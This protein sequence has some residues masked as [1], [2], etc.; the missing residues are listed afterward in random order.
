MRFFL[1]TSDSQSVRAG[2]ETGALPTPQN[3]TFAQPVVTPIKWYATARWTNFAAATSSTSNLAAVKVEKDEINAALKSMNKYKNSSIF[4]DGTGLLG[5]VSGSPSTTTIT[6]TGGNIYWFKRNM[7]VEFYSSGS[8]VAGPVKLTDVD[9]INNTVSTETN[10]SSSLTSGD[11]IYKAGTHSP[12]SVTNAE[13]LGIGAALSAT[14]SYLGVARTDERGWQAQVIDGGSADVD[15]DIMFQGEERVTTLA[16]E[17][18]NVED[19]DVV[20]HPTQFRKF[21]KLVSSRRRFMGQSADAGLSYQDGVEWEGKKFLFDPDCKRDEV[22]MIPF[23]TVKRFTVP[24]GEQQLDNTGGSV[25]KW[26]P[27]YDAAFA[28]WKEFSQIAFTV[29]AACVRIHTLAVPAA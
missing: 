10:V 20:I 25:V 7:T 15:E 11:S 27:N 14:N 2:T 26:T 21:F 8:R 5:L 17:D 1:R 22:L 9:Y 28:Y 4:R 19:L 29:P 12:T 16:G 13:W 23:H 24:G 3:S 6:I 18:V